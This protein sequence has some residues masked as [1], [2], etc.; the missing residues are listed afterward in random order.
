MTTPG[1]L[2]IDTASGKVTG[3]ANITYNDPFPCVNGTPGVTG[4][5]QGVLLHTMVSDLPACVATFN[6]PANQASAHFGIAEDGEIWQFGPIGKGWEAWH[7]VAANLTWYGIEHADAGHPD[8]PLT[9]AQIVASAQLLELL[10]RFCGFPLQVTDRPASRGYGTHSMGGAAW[11]GHTCPDVPPEHVRSKQ[12]QAIV[13]LAKKIRNP[14]PPPPSWQSQ[15]AAHVSAA[16]SHN[17][18]AAR[19]MA[20]AAELIAANP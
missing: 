19:E 18:S 12:R 17:A 4:A 9:P 3:P 1:R 8:T 5:M 7:A 11:G 6:N 13:D 15:A 2:Q 10:S 14:P 16:I 20:T